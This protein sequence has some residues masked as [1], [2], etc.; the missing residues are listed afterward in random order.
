M[1]S[2]RYWN[3]KDCIYKPRLYIRLNKK[4]NILLSSIFIPSYKAQAKCF[5]STHFKFYII[6]FLFSNQSK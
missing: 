5:Q 6:K 1:C 3:A 2:Y 4:V